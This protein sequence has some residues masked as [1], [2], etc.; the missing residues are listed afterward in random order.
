MGIFMVKKLF[1][2]ITISVVFLLLLSSC[3]KSSES[4][5][6]AYEAPAV[7]NAVGGEYADGQALSEEKSLPEVQA[8]Q[9]ADSDYTSKV[10]R[11][12]KVNIRAVDVKNAYAQYLNYIK[13]N[14]G[15]EFSMD[16]SSSEDYTTINAT[17][18]I[19]P[20]CLDDAVAYASECGDV[21]YGNVSSEDIT[22]EYYD[23]KI[24]LENKYKNL[25]KYYEYLENAHQMDEIIQL[26][27]QIDIITSDIEAFEGR[28]RMWDALTNESTIQIS[29]AQKNDP[30]QI[31]EEFDWNTMTAEK[32]GRHMLN[33][34]KKTCN[35]I[36][37]VVQW[38]IIVIV[39]LIPVIVIAG[40]VITIIILRI[41]VKKKKNPGTET[42]TDDKKQ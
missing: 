7:F 10:I 18:K 39:T 6:Y 4:A 8:T 20:S 25:E 3:S 5:D 23:A 42:Q 2:A 29:F 14:G 27:N 31:D 11:N 16:M 26:Q 21:T 38:L 9:G 19:K 40:V 36:F 1:A 22:S 12:A 35:A 28:L 37:S 15:Y 13:E 30:N 32:M 24:R 17:L 34:F 33:G 41:K